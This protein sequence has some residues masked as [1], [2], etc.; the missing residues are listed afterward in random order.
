MLIMNSWSSD[1]SGP[2]S[3]CALTGVVFRLLFAK[4]ARN[5]RVGEEHSSCQP[6]HGSFQYG[7]DSDHGN[8]PTVA[9]P[10]GLSLQATPEEVKGSEGMGVMPVSSSCPFL[11]I[12][13]K[14]EG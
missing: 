13:G 7:L 2:D 1:I 12:K 14:R 9:R 8:N 10:H 4:A 11:A 6:S 5:P 3:V